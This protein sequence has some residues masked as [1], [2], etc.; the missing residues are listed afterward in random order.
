MAKVEHQ[1][2]WGIFRTS[3]NLVSSPYTL[4]IVILLK[5]NA[6]KEVEIWLGKTLY[7]VLSNCIIQII[8]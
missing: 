8:K 1:D 3:N 6:I 2:A 7:I 4:L 5:V